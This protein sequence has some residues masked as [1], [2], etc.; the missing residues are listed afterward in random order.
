M[1]FR[2]GGFVRGESE[3]RSYSWRGALEA[4]RTA[5]NLRLNFDLSGSRFE[6]QTDVP[7]LD[8]TFTNTQTRIN[9]RSQ[10]VW[11]IGQHWAAGAQA[12]VFK[13]TF[14]NHALGFEG[15]PAIEYNIYPYSESTRRQITLFY[16]IGVA[17]YDYEEITILSETAEVLPA[18]EFELAAEFQQPWGEID[19]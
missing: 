17:A 1:L 10:A 19:G 18:H 7:E 11:S 6:D 14:T 12:R 16:Q 5:E 2:S 15:G 9:F 3:Q 8:T 13:S 4:D